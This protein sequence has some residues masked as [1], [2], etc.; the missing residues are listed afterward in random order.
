M[1]AKIF[2]VKSRDKKKYWYYLDKGRGEGGREALGLYTYVKPGDIYERQYNEQQMAIIRQRQGEMLIGS[3]KK[4]QKTDFLYF[5]QSYVLENERPGKRHL[6]SSLTHFK[7]FIQE[8]KINPDN[9]TEDNCIAFRRWLLDRFNGETPLNYFSCFKAVIK[10]AHKSGY[11][12]S[13]IAEDI[14][15]KKNPSKGRDFLTGDEYL[16]LSAI[17]C[18][19]PEIYR[20]AITSL[21]TGL[22]WCDVK[23]LKYEDIKDDVITLKRKKSKVVGRIPI[24]KSLKQVLLTG[25]GP[26]FNLPTA[27]GCNKILKAWA[28]TAGIDK[29]ITWHCLRLSFSVE[30]L[31][32][33]INNSTVAG[34]M[35]HT[36]TTMVNKTYRRY[37]DDDGLAAIKLL[38]G[39]D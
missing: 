3:Q 18:P 6:P 10:S 13:N 19:N 32:K 22:A 9:L 39:N 37:V 14:K 21:Y 7:T 1:E 38:P 11:F 17:P 31:R 36:S 25:T 27:N 8:K 35:L 20:A 29:H 34:L 5:Y 26:V 23:D 12:E 24:H 28:N 15:G 16:K 4:K 33:G 30:L 2:K